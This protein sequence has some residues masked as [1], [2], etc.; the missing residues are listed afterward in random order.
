MISHT[1]MKTRLCLSLTALFFACSVLLI[2]LFTATS[3]S[4]SGSH[5]MAGR[6][7]YFGKEILPDNVLYPVMM[8]TDR[9]QL[10][11]ASNYDRIFMQVEYANRRLD[12]SKQLLDEEK[13]ALAVTTLTKAEKYLHNAIQEAIE[14]KASDSIKERLRKSL[15]YHST[16]IKK[17]SPQFTDGDRA[18]LDK[19]IEENNATLPSLQ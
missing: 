4:S 12:Y 3:A 11:T 7:L 19:L 13:Q 10:E 18:L 14:I 17:M 2:S 9:V 5:A 1:T 15:E 16:Q 8:A 6:K